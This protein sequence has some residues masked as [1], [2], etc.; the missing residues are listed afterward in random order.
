MMPIVFF[1]YVILFIYI[2]IHS[3][4]IHGE[5]TDSVKEKMQTH[6]SFVTQ[7]RYYYLHFRT[8]LENIEK[9]EETEKKTDS[10]KKVSY[11]VS[12]KSFFVC[13]FSFPVK[14]QTPFVL[15][16]LRLTS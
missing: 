5:D 15:F 9:Q 4:I 13:L 12:M 3:Q 1:L 16:G 10:E 11:S 7:T 14:K 6:P 2:L 8:F